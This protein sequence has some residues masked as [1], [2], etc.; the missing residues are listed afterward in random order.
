M[1]GGSTQQF[2]RRTSTM[3][4]FT[5][6]LSASGNTVSCLP[7][8]LSAVRVQ[9]R[10]TALFNATHAASRTPWSGAVATTLHTAPRNPGTRCSWTAPHEAPSTRPCYVGH[11]QCWV[12]GI[13]Q[14]HAPHTALL[15]LGCASHCWVPTC[16]EA[17]LLAPPWVT[18]THSTPCTRL[19]AK[20]ATP[21]LATQLQCQCDYA[22]WHSN[23]TP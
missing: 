17:P 18:V 20:E 23:H 8:T 11:M 5:T 21:T 22:R 10:V 12:P 14:V 7:F 16:L 2:W 13:G 19:A 1:C 15:L 3:F 4:V 9:F 6:A